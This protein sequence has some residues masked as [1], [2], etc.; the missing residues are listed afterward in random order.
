ML[1]NFNTTISQKY[2]LTKTS[3]LWEEGHIKVMAISRYEYGCLDF[4]LVPLKVLLWFLGHQKY[5]KSLQVLC[6][7]NSLLL[8]PLYCCCNTAD[9][10]SP[11]LWLSATVQQCG[12]SGL[13]HSHWAAAN[14]HRAFTMTTIHTAL[15]AQTHLLLLPSNKSLV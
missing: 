14:L 5:C 15:T 2:G 1:C 3:N 13:P 8:F 10:R 4:S 11:P 12:S 7:S 9:Q 6:Q